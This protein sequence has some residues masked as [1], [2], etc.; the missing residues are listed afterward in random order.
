[1]RRVLSLAIAGAFVLLCSSQAQAQTVVYTATLSGSNEAP[2]VPATGAGGFATVTVNMTTQTIDWVVDVYNLPSGVTAAHIHVGGP[3]VAGPVVINFT[4]PTS[5]SNDF[6]ISGSARA[7]DVVARQPQGVNT[8]E[9]L[10]QAMATGH[11]YVNVHSQVNGGGEI[12]GQLAV[13][14]P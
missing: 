9:D 12:R 2:P 5:A 10:V 4:V 8:F 7:A 13:R 11:A 6:R 3:G 14:Q 1:M